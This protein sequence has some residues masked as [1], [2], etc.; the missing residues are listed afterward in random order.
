MAVPRQK[1]KF[2]RFTR[3]E[4]IHFLKGK[5][6]IPLDAGFVVVEVEQGDDTINVN[7]V[8]GLVISWGP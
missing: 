6:K 2:I 4:L 3:S 7:D 5:G 8:D 1:G